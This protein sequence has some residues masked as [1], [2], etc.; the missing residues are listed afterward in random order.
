MTTMTTMSEPSPTGQAGARPDA[1][2]MVDDYELEQMAADRARH[3]AQQ[4]LQQV[5]VALAR[6]A[7][8]PRRGSPFGEL[9]GPSWGMLL[10]IE[11]RAFGDPGLRARHDPAVLATLPRLAGRRGIEDELDAEANLRADDDDLP[12]VIGVAAALLGAH[13]SEL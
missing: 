12:L 7:F 2:W 3:R 13:D 10:A 9:R 5:L 4:D 6:R 11:A 8:G 1:D